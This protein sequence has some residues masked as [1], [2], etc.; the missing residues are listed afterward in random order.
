MR[1]GK[2]FVPESFAPHNTDASVAGDIG[3]DRIPRPMKYA[4]AALISFV[5]FA[6]L[7][8]ATARG[9]LRKLGR[10]LRDLGKAGQELLTGEEI[11]GSPLARYESKA[12]ALIAARLLARYPVSPEERLQ[13]LV[14]AIGEKLAARACRREIPYRFSVVEA[15]E[16]N[17]FAAPGGF[18]FVTTGLIEICANDRDRVAAALAHE[19]A[20]VD[21]RHAVRAL[22]AKAAMKAGLRLATLGRSAILEHIARGVEELF[23][24]GY[25]RE[26]EL[27]ADSVGAGLAH[28]A[29]FDPRGMLELFS[30]LEKLQAQQSGPLQE[31]LGY[32]G[33][34]PPIAARKENVARAIAHLKGRR[35]FT[36]GS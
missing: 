29:G 35:A 23:A 20:H 22:A 32:L 36:P 10:T 8:P 27:E 26:Q 5:I 13:A 31:I 33:S 24:S 4:I 16:P 12:G 15:P 18:V 30:A 9:I 6:I 17:A 3:R 11:E 19:I 7:F 1:L 2:G 14:K 34:H 25:G 21:R 28:A